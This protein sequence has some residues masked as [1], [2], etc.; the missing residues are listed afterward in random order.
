[1]FETESM[2]ASLFFGSIGAGYFIYGKNQ[3]NL[4][5]LACGGAVCVVPYMASNV[6][7]MVPICAILMAVP[8]LVSTS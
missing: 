3:H 7:A 5:A 8:F 4:L 6:S 2:M 1:M